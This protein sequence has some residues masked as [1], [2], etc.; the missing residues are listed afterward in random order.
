MVEVHEIKKFR[1]SG[2]ALKRFISGVYPLDEDQTDLC[3]NYI[4]KNYIRKK[5]TRE[6]ITPSYKQKSLND[7]E[8]SGQ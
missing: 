8:K 1:L 5:E 6:N 2:L 4:E 3:G 7:Y